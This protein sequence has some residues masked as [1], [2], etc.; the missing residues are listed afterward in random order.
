MGYPVGGRGKKVPYSS[1]VVRVP[2]PV[3]SKVEKII[4]AFYLAPDSPYGQDPVAVVT[5]SEMEDLIAIILA[6]KVSAPKSFG[7]LLQKMF[8]VSTDLA[9]HRNGG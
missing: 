7:L 6:R 2:D 5:R 8:P 4:E 1:S 9:P 3:K